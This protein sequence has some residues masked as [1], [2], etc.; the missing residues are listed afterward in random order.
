MTT[1][2]TRTLRVHAIDPARLDDVRRAGADGF[3]NA[4]DPFPATGAGEPVRCCLRFAR[5]GE[6]IALISFAR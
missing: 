5:A 3:G 1:T 6:S 4:I 2:E